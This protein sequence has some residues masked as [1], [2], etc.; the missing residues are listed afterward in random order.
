MNK[1]AKSQPKDGATR[2]EQSD[3]LPH[4]KSDESSRYSRL[5]K[6]ATRLMNGNE[7]VAKRWLRTPLLILGDKSPLEHACTEVGAREVER[8]IGRI[9]HGVY[10]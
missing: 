1:S 5:L 9:E 3:N 8:L 2:L 4:D 7:A 10:S 6:S